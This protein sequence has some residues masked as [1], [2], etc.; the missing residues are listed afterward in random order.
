MPMNASNELQPHELPDRADVLIVGGGPCGLML[1]NELGRRG[2]RAVLVDQKPG[3]AFNPQA[4]ATQARTM[5]HFRRLGF[6]QEVRALGLPADFPTDV[7]Y[8]TRFANHEL[9]RFRLPS[10]RE[11]VGKVSRL[12]GAW[13]AAELPHR[14]S[15]KYVEAVLLRHAQAL[16]GITMAYGWRL[17]SFEDTG[18]EVRA[19]LHRVGDEQA[20][21]LTCRYL[22]GADGARSTVRH[23]LGWGYTGEAAIARDFMGGRM[24]AIYLRSSAFYQAAPHAP[25]WM[26]VCFNPQRRAFMCAVDGRGEFA[27]HTQLRPDE[28]EEDL[29]DAQALAMFHAAVGQSIPAQILSRGFWTAGHCLVAERFQR[30]RVLI[31]GDAAHLF[32][33]TGGLGYNTA[34]DDAVN[35]GWKLAAAIRGGAGE[36]LMQSYSQ[37]RQP[38]A[39]RNTGYA[40]GFADSLGLFEPDPRIEEDSAEG[41]QARLRAGRYLLAHGQAEFD[42]PGITFGVRYDGS[43]AIVADGTNPPPDS[44]HT[45]HPSACPGGRAPHAWLDDGRSL[46]DH[47][48]FEWTLLSLGRDRVDPQPMVDAAS[49]LATTVRVVRMPT[50]AL[51]ELYEA[52]LVLIRP[53]QVVAWR[54]SRLSDGARALEQMLRGHTNGHEA[55]RLSG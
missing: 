39:H 45:Y 50:P 12:G 52:D 41:V 9:A 16:D 54:G 5:E 27:F 2:V 17:A 38:A 15:Q 26:N 4:N 8:F 3:T 30:G 29:T 40:R 55:A 11:A 42:I 10:A 14:V 13:S 44:A 1:A 47:F 20:A 37:E 49:R 35:L 33:P 24:L 32:T 51:R 23:Q 34:I 25:A 48:G 31:A 19:R 46:F 43:S 6:A 7:A 22:V 36:A 18:G 28:R 53:D 21:T